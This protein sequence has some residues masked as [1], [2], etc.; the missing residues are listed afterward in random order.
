[1][2]DISKDAGC[3]NYVLF[4][5]ICLKPVE[6]PE[7]LASL[8]G[9]TVLDVEPRVVGEI[10]PCAWF[11]VAFDP[12]AMVDLRDHETLKFLRHCV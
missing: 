1:M 12:R 10:W 4:Q 11:E 7:C 3:H 2:L 8:L 9:V 5:S 6:K